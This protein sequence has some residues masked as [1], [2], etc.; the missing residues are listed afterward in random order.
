MTMITNPLAIR[1]VQL[2]AQMSAVNLESLGMRRRGRSISAMLKEFYGLPKSASYSTLLE[3]L[4]DDLD[5]VH[6]QLLA[7]THSGPQA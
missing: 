6:E 5:N 4:K 7:Q 3:S 1:A 2:R